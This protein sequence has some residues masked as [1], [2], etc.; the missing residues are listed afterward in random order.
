M[1]RGPGKRGKFTYSPQ[2]SK[3]AYMRTPPGMRYKE[4]G[5]SSRYQSG[6]W[7]AGHKGELHPADAVDLPRLQQDFTGHRVRA[8]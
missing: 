1:L 7:E 3:N 2:K 4:N 5:P 6:G 8:G